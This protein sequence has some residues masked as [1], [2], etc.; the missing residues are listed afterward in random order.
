MDLLE[1]KRFK[2]LK[3]ESPQDVYIDSHNRL[4]S[5]VTNGGIYIQK[6]LHVRQ[7]IS[8]GCTEK[9]RAGMIRFNDESGK[10]ELCPAD[11]SD[12][13]EIGDSKWACSG[14]D[15][16]FLDGKVGIGTS[17]PQKILD[18]NGDVLIQRRLIVRDGLQVGHS[19]TALKGVIRFNEETIRFEGYNGKEWIQLD[20]RLPDAVTLEEPP[21]IV[22]NELKIDKSKLCYNNSGELTLVTND[23]KETI[24]YDAVSFHVD[25]GKLFFN[26][27]SVN[28]RFI[29]DKAIT[30]RKINDNSITNEKIFPLTITGDKIGHKTIK[31]ENLKDSGIRVICGNGLKGSRYVELGGSIEIS[32]DNVMP[33]GS[34]ILC[35]KSVDIP[36]GWNE[37]DKIPAPSNALRY[38]VKV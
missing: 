15:I 23:E 33:V 7:G 20:Q 30:T 18:V 13:C 34:V 21:E 24:E 38:I 22:P 25:S 31:N 4:A 6:H 1:S 2:T 27:Q 36:D 12:F 37:Y 11:D 29:S 8:L 9:K 26:E 16:F 35:D 17:D 32:L 5:L 14:N 10:L 3:L 28:T 19:T